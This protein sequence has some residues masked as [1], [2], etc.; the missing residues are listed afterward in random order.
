MSIASIFNMSTEK[1]KTVSIPHVFHSTE[2]DADVKAADYLKQPRWFVFSEYGHPEKKDYLP[3]FLRYEVK[4]PLTLC[5]DSK[6]EAREGL[7]GYVVRQ[8]YAYALCLF[9]PSEC[10]DPEFVHVKNPKSYT[11]EASI[12]ADVEAINKMLGITK[13]FT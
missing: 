2:L 8:G 5:V 4:K 7:D 3:L 9:R 1:V 13:R 12:D 6:C 10:L 11:D